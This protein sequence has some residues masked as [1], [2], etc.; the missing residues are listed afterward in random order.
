MVMFGTGG[1][2]GHSALAVWRGDQLY[3]SESTDANPFG[4]VYWPPPYGI[5]THKYEDWVPLAVKAG[6]HVGVLPVTQAYADSFNETAYWNWFESVQ[7]MP[8]GYHTMLFSFLVC[9]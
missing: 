8:Y 2:T 1:V 7:G 4:P 5:I 3:V 6:Y 9:W